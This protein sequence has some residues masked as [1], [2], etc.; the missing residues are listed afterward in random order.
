MACCFPEGQKS[1]SILLFED[2]MIVPL[3]AVVAFLS[4]LSDGQSGWMDV[5]WRSVLCS[6]LLACRNGA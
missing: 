2:L 5:A 1:I 4:P 3:L 6:F